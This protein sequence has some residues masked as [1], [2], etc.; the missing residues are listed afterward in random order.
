MIGHVCTAV[1]SE[2]DVHLYGEAG[3]R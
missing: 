1:E 3:K 2:L